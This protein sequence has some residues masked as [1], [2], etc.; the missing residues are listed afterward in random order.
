MQ[1]GH[2]EDAAVD[3]ESAKEIGDGV[4]FR[5]DKNVHGL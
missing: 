3:G 1:L 5:G 4:G 2:A